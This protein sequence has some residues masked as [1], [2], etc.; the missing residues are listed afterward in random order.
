MTIMMGGGHRNGVAGFGFMSGRD[1]A[2]LLIICLVVMLSM[3][4]AY[5]SGGG[6]SGGRYYEYHNGGLRAA[7]ASG[8][9]AAN[10]RRCAGR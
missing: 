10:S 6:V 1:C 3:V 5:S 7:R 4:W 2:A 9:E 8:L